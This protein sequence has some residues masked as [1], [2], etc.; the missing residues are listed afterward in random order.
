MAG[1]DLPHPGD[2]LIPRLRSDDAIDG[3]FDT[4][5]GSRLAG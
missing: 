2:A 5:H 4:R 1:G 3:L